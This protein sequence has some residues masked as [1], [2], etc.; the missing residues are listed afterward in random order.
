[1]IRGRSV[2]GLL[3]VALALIGFTAAVLVRVAIGGRAIAGSQSAALV[4]AGAL[5]LLTLAL[6]G[7]SPAFSRK[8]VL[9]GL[10]GAAVLCVPPLI[11]HTVHPGVRPQ[12]SYAH[13]ALVVTI[14]A[15]AEE[16]FMRGAVYTAIRD[17]RGKSDDTAA[18]IV[19]AVAFAALHL[20][21]YG[22]GSAPLD[23]A[24]GLLLGVL[25]EQTGGW[26]APAI[27]HVL[28]DLA[29]WWLR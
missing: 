25:R 17:W 12:G 5:A 19:T 23:L 28:A 27:T 26:A 20:P 1:M 10:A 15:V 13:W 2:G 21:L 6:G 11:G 14:V 22:W 18:L 7:A 24:V 29:G 3:T 4:F 8:A 16:A 9:L